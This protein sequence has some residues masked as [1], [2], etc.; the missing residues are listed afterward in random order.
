META[1][2]VALVLYVGVGLSTVSAEVAAKGKVTLER[3]VMAALW[4]LIL[5]YGVSVHAALT[6]HHV[7]GR[8]KAR[9]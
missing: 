4:P 7:I 6:V 3:T 5:V 9:K 8:W 1:D 2:W